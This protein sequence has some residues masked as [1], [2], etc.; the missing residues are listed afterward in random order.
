[1]NN[2]Y[3][4]PTPSDILIH[5]G[6]G[7][8]KWGVRNGPPYP[9]TRSQASASEKKKGFKESK[10]AKNPKGLRKEIDKLSDQEL[11][12]R[13]TRLEKEKRYATLLSDKYKSDGRRY[14]EKI[15]GKLLTASIVAAGTAVSGVLINSLIK[16][17]LANALKSS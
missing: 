16:Q 10:F 14:I 13:L 4:K 2:L 1:M 7:G 8:M 5:E 15:G 9:L 3:D 11:D 12:K 17:P 6:I